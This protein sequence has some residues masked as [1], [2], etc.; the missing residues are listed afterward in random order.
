M[1]RELVEQL[2]G[3][4]TLTWGA[5]AIQVRYRV[6]VYQN[7]IDDGRSGHIVGRQHVEASASGRNRMFLAQ[8]YHARAPLVLQ[9]DDG[10]RLTCAI[11]RFEIVD[12]DVVLAP[13]GGG[14]R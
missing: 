3:D 13:D 14:L 10:R 2:R 5:N 8:A 4:G 11:Q 12:G 9:L 1:G 6:D 7:W